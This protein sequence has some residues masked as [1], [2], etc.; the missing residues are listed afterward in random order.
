MKLIFSGFVNKQREIR[1]LKKQLYSI[2][3]ENKNLKNSFALEKKKFIMTTKKNLRNGVVLFLKSIVNSFTLKSK[4]IEILN[5]EIE[6]L[7]TENK[8]LQLKKQNFD[9]IIQSLQLSLEPS[10]LNLAFKNESLN[11]NIND[12]KFQK[13][14]RDLDREWSKIN[15]SYHS[16]GTVDRAQR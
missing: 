4:R 6:A 16:Q 1:D 5:V 2:R 13:S 9:Y 8:A 12:L 14:Q 10:S 15:A 7:R 11:L 3:E